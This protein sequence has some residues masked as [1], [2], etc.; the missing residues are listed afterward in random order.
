MKIGIDISETTGEKTGVGYY[1]THLVEALAA[2]DRVNQ[3]TL[4]PVFFDNFPPTY[5]RATCPEQDNFSLFGKSLSRRK[6]T[7]LWHKSGMPKEQ[8][9]G[10]QDV[11]HSTTFSSPE[12]TESSLIVTL[13]DLSFWT[14]PQC[15]RPI[16]R[17]YCAERCCLA[18][19]RASRLIAISEATKRDILKYLHVPEERVVVTPLA[20]H[21]RFRPV[22]DAWCKHQVLMKYGLLTDYIFSL[23]SLEPRKNIAT[24]IRAY[25]AL[26]DRLR[27]TTHLAIAGAKGWKNSNL[28]ALIEQLSL[29]DCVKVLGY[30]PDDDLPALYS[31]ASV[32][33]YPSLYEGFG[34][35]ALEAMACGA[36]VIVSNTSSL[37]EVVGTAGIQIEPT[38]V[39]ALTQAILRV[40]LQPDLSEELRRKGIEQAHRFSWQRTAELTLQ[41]YVD[42]A[43]EKN[44]RK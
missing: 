24:L 30:V 10:Q 9:F 4:Y 39:E 20:A 1:T 27:R 3:Y 44:R 5:D 11:F 36:P 32:F 13:Y 34:L 2:V 12:L 6:L 15:H 19:R 31:S 38:D 22:E 42:A 18:A 7:H 17:R 37:P 29:G 14:H 8:L 21:P 23:G 33:V 40:L 41:A 16:N 26:P 25:S 28:F 43:A 35:P